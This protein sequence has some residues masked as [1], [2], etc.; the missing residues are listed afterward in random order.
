LKDGAKILVAY[1]GSE[2]SNRALSEA[3]DLAKKFSGSVTLLHVFWDPTM[4]K[5]E[6]TEVRDQPTMQLLADAEKS[7]KA[8][9]IKYEMRSERS[10]DPPYVILK[11]AKDEGFDCITLGSRGRGGAKAWILGSVSSRVVAES[12][13]PVIVVK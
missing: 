8:A 4:G 12:A 5:L 3:A 1:D 11:T 7:L 9:K 2:Y 6:G 10:N 13:C